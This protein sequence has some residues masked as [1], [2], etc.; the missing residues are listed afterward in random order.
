[1]STRVHI[2]LSMRL[3]H[4]HPTSSQRPLGWV[5][6]RWTLLTW[7]REVIIVK[8]RMK[9]TTS[10]MNKTHRSDIS[11]VTQ[12]ESCMS[13]TLPNLLISK[14]KV[15]R[16]VNR[17]PMHMGSVQN[18]SILTYP[19]HRYNLSMLMNQLSLSMDLPN[20]SILR[21][22]RSHLQQRAERPRVVPLH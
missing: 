3:I 17:P 22:I 20:T 18:N 8:S 11:R 7:W 5:N 1:M 9:L 4:S 15:L 13:Q 21:H 6:L 19:V 14:G 2:V 16:R 12:R 10:S